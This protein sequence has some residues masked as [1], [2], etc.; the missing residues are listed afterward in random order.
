MS[1]SMKSTEFKSSTKEQINRILDLNPG[2]QTQNSCQEVVY[3]LNGMTNDGQNMN[4]QYFE[5]TQVRSRRRL[6]SSGSDSSSHGV[7]QQKPLFPD[8]EIIYVDLKDDDSLFKLALHFKCSVSN[9]FEY[10]CNS[11]LYYNL[12]TEKKPVKLT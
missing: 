5:L 6:D 1:Q 8:K 9:I 11:S 2:I 10:M 12:W 7:S 4:N 3:I